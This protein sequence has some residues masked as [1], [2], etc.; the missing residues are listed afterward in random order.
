MA[1][2]LRSRCAFAR[3]FAGKSK[4]ILNNT[5]DSG[6][7]FFPESQSINFLTSQ[8]SSFAKSPF[9]DKITEQYNYEITK[10]PTEWKFV[11]RLMPFK[12]IPQVVPK[13]SYPSGWIPPKEEARKLPYFIPRTKNYAI[14]IYLQLSFKG[15]RKITQLKK[16]EGDIWLMNDDIKHLL[17]T[18]HK[19]YVETRVHEV[20][21]FIEIKG[22]YVNDMKEW[23]FSKG[24]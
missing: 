13:E 5:I 17:K 9:V 12:T 3:L 8:Y 16:I 1:T 6:A 19:R 21:R 23:A 2:V 4:G 24:F 20:A 10:N 15:N 18:K 11:E 14:P 22:D 7:K